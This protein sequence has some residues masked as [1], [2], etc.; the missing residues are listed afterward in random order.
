MAM[1]VG[2]A[3]AIADDAEK[4]PYSPPLRDHATQLLWGDTHL[5]SSRSADAYTT[6]VRITPSQAYEFARG[7]SAIADNGVPLKLKRPLDFLLLSDHSDYLGIYPML[8]ASDPR[9]KNWKVGQRWAAYLRDNEHVKLGSEF[10]AAIQQSDPADDVPLETARSI[11]SDVAALAD[12]YND[13]G[14]FTALIGYEWTSMITGDNLHRVIM[15]RDGAEKASQ[16]LPF[17]ARDSTDPE[18]LWRALEEY[19]SIT[20]GEVL[21]I[22][23]NGNVSNGRMFSP[24]TVSGDPL[25]AAY[26]KMRSR[27]E[28]VYEVTQVKGD[29]EAHPILSPSDEF[30]DF[31]TW[32]QGNIM[33]SVDKEP[34]ML[35]YEYA[36]P[37]LKEGLRHEAELGTNPFKFG[38]IGSTDFHTGFSTPEENNFFGKFV[39][40]NPSPDRIN[41]PMAGQLQEGWK[42]GASGLAAVWASENTRDAIFEAMKRREVY[43]TTGPR[44]QV[45]FFGGWDFEAADIDRSDYVRIGYEAGVP[46]GGD[47]IGGEGNEAPS[48]LIAASRDPDGANL[49]RVQVIKGWLEDNGETR[50]RIYDVALSDGREVNV[51]TGQVPPV[52]NTVNMLQ[53]SYSNAI[54]D[55][56]LATVWRDPDFEPDQR[57][58]YYL[59][60]LQIPTPRWT[61]YDAGYF[62]VQMP[63]GIPMVV[64]DRAYTSPIWY[65]P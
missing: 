24:K 64:Q 44:I 59:R 8:D 46:M 50:E 39:E 10:A 12:R 25:D 57:A 22:A 11:W 14:V 43:A 15:Y 45:R 30:A 38:L 55:P 37:A 26:A 53:P 17:T 63:D 20:G 47:L 19:E 61:A 13:P 60:V 7:G 5:H 18:D 29:G 27:W 54:G 34:W 32:D 48:F 40:T 51:E 4:V 9:L 3:S 2:A 23:H 36:R 62:D 33:L 35:Q 58:F 6:G 52:G 42:L 21:A 31:E 16:V 65:T 1:V 56:E 41:N 49:D 28:P